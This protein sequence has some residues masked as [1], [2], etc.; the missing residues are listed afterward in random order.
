MKTTAHSSMQRRQ[1]QQSM[2]STGGGDS[3]Q[4]KYMCNIFIW[5]MKRKSNW[6]AGKVNKASSEEENGTQSLY[7]LV[8]CSLPH[9]R[10]QVTFVSFYLLGTFHK[11]SCRLRFVY[12]KRADVQYT[13]CTWCIHDV[14]K[15]I[16]LKWVA[17]IH[18]RLA[19]CLLSMQQTIAIFYMDALCRVII[20]YSIFAEGTFVRQ[21]AFE[22]L[23]RLIGI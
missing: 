5:T 21:R 15:L 6:I 13:N 10:S 11:E 16:R 20:E 23:I 19:L 18:V 14:L 3:E 17:K 22:I 12:G 4:R 8:K 7:S 1:Q 2:A 9:S